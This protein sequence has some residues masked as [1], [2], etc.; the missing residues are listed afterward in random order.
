M[1]GSGSDE[2]KERQEA[3]INDK[4]LQQ[5]E[6]RFRAIFEQ[7]PMAIGLLTGRDMTIE[8]GNDRLFE[9]WGKSPEI[10]GMK[11]LDALPEIKDQR[12]LGILQ[13]VYDSGE[14]FFG[15][16]VKAHLIR[17]SKPEYAYFDFTYTALRNANGEVVGVMVLATEV[18]DQMLARQAIEASEAKLRSVIA[19]APAAMGLF[20]GRDLIVEMPNQAFI[21]IV[22]KGPDI[23]GKPLKEVMPELS[24]QPFLKILDDVYTTGVT[25]KTD[26]AQ[27][28][29]VRNGT[30][31]HNFYNITYSPLRNAEG[32]IYAILDIAIDVTETVHAR[33]QLEQAQ[34]QLKGAIELA[35]LGTWTL[36]PVTLEMEYDERMQKWLGV[37]KEKRTLPLAIG[38]LLPHERE[39]VRQAFDDALDPDTAGEFDLEF[40]LINHNTAKTRLVK[41]R[42]SELDEANE[43]LKGINEKLQ[44]N[45]EA[46][47]KLNNSL[48]RSN[49]ELQQFAHVTSHDLKEPLRKI[50]M[51]LDRLMKTAGE[52]LPPGS[53]QFVDRMRSACDRMDA[54]I[55]GVLEYAIIDADQQPPAP[56]SL[57]EI[58]NTIV[59]DLQ[60]LISSKKAEIVFNDLPSVQ[61]VSILLYQLF[62]NLVI[63]ALKFAK[64]GLT[65]L[66]RISA[67]PVTLNDS[68]SMISISVADNG[69]GFEEQYSEEI[70][71]TF[72]RLHS[73]DKFEG[74]G[75]GLALCKRIAERHGGTITAKGTSGVGATFNILLPIGENEKSVPR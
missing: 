59:N 17:N 29:I 63:N 58:M 16:G 53:Q 36:D 45:N 23:V 14:P 74:T 12:F 18:T 68:R 34:E 27:V 40:H 51:N 75:L 42:T 47:E 28:N 52:S 15:S 10:T 4:L 35:E 43:Q 8:I 5:S 7:A 57:Q 50:Y 21:D 69:I 30:M 6:E 66:I 26:A 73:K 38:R 37:P 1:Q 44:A 32:K 65:P 39:R 49:E 48:M 22:G 67:D 56:V 31:T 62:Y 70:F 71:R 55:R 9:L 61:G 64:P 13:T 60:E 20:T 3:L 41:E 11:L 24:S 2:F 72:S 54:M 46:L 25:Y 19:T 33:Q